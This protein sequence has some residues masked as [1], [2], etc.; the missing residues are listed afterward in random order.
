M[1]LTGKAKEDFELWV[2]NT[3][4][5]NGN[6]Q[7][8]K[9][10]FY[11]ESIDDYKFINTEHYI[12]NIGESMLYA[13]IIEWLDSLGLIIIIDYTNPFWYAYIMEGVGSHS[14]DY[15]GFCSRQEA[16]KQAILKANELY[17]N[18]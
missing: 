1:I 11:I 13:L 10:L 17:N 12:H 5:D 16:T 7:T 3:H 15:N 14:T 2:N 6:G 9:R 18:K 4:D 8:G